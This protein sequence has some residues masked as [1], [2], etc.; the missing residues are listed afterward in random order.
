MKVSDFINPFHSVWKQSR[1]IRR[2]RPLFHAP[3]V[4][5][6]TQT[7]ISLEESSSTS[8]GIHNY[9]HRS[10][11]LSVQPVIL[12]SAVFALK[13]EPLPSTMNGHA[14]SIVYNFTDRSSLSTNVAHTSKVFHC[15][16]EQLLFFISWI[17]RPTHFHDSCKGFSNIFVDVAA[18]CSSLCR[19]RDDIFVPLNL[20]TLDKSLT[21]IGPR[22]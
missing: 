15:Y 20:A 4:E 1:N 8:Q 5:W 19:L 7:L 14:T 3:A 22:T 2:R 16:V 11:H 9:S 17:I 21:D 12:L 6:P 13:V 10:N 18:S